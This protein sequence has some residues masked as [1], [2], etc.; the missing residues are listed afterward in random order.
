MRVT[1]PVATDLLSEG[2]TLHLGERR[3]IIEYAHLSANGDATMARI[4]FEEVLAVDYRD[5]TCASP[6]SIIGFREVRSLQKSRF[7]D[8]VL[9]TWA[10]RSGTT[11]H[12]AT[13][14]GESR[15]RHFTVW[16]DDIAAI[17]VVAASCRAE[18]PEA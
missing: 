17:D 18:I 11:E 15:Y 1:L 2:P 10:S 4:R 7:L 9:E 12:D 3:M 6:D 13:Q 8:S 14:A 5:W 16:F